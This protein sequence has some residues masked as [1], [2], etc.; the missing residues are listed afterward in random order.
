MQHLRQDFAAVGQA[1]A[2]AIEVGIAVGKENATVQYRI[3]LGWPMKGPQSYGLQV[4]F[5]REGM[6][7]LVKIVD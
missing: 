4:H 7:R 2:G 3:D 1:R 6:V 5:D